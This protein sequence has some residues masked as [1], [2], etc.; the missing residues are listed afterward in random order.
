MKQD[1]LRRFDS[2]SLKQFRMSQRKLNHLP[3]L[4]DHGSQT[5]Y[6]LVADLGNSADWFLDLFADKNLRSFSN[7][8]G[9]R[10]GTCVRHNRV[11]SPSHDIDRDEVPPRQNPSLQELAKIL[12]P[13]D[14]TE[15]LCRG[16]HQT[17]RDL[18]IYLPNSNLVINRDS[19]V[20]P[21]I[22]V[23][24]DNAFSIILFMCWPAQRVRLPLPNNLDDIARGKPEFLDNFRVYSS[25]PSPH[26]S[27]DS[28]R[29]S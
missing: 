15:R 13:A 16:Q 27:L 2:Q 23:Y 28:I 20:V 11:D 10:R 7:D 3:D 24:T 9:S 6:V 29:D 25:Y 21:E 22:A 8:L 14:N 17:F 4:L 12:F 19:R 18:R 1:T 26:V 5:A